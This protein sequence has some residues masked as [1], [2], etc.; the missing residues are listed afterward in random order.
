MKDV[1]DRVQES[2]KIDPQRESLGAI[3][4]VGLYNPF[5]TTPFGKMLTPFVNRWNVLMVER[6]GNDPNI[7][8]VQTSDI[9]RTATGC[10]STGSIRT[11]RATR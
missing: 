1:L 8:I 7:V 9:S 6:F 3:F 5:I 4:V 10:R 2:V 11:M